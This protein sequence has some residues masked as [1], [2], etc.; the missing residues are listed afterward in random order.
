MNSQMCRESDRMLNLAREYVRCTYADRIHRHRWRG[1]GTEGRKEGRKGASCQF[2]Q[3]VPDVSSTPLVPGLPKT[4][5]SVLRE[6]PCTLTLVNLACT[7]GVGSLSGAGRGRGGEGV[8]RARAISAWS[9]QDS[10][11]D[12][13]SFRVRAGARNVICSCSGLG[14]MHAPRHRL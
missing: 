1:E 3:N 11:R 7:G 14:A 4:P 13:V 9:P 5:D 12:I 6:S 8:A 2:A 10:A